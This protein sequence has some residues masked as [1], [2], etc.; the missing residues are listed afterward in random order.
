MI[1]APAALCLTLALPATAA[2]PSPASV[3][4]LF[5]LAVRPPNVHYKGRKLVVTRHGNQSL[6]R[7][8][9][10]Y[11]SPPN[12]WRHEVLGPS[13]TVLKTTI[14]SGRNEWIRAAGSDKVILRDVRRIRR[15]EFDGESLHGLLR[16]NY[17]LK[18]AGKK[19][20]LGIQ[21]NGIILEPR[22]GAGSKRALWVDP[23]TG[24]VVLRRESSHDGKRMQESR[25]TRLEIA[26]NLPSELFRPEFPDDPEV[27]EEDER[28][29]IESAAHLA[30]LGLARSLWRESLPFGYRLDSVNAVAVGPETVVHMRYTNGL[31]LLSLFVSPRAIDAEDLRVEEGLDPASESGV[32]AVTWAGGVLIWKDG[33]RHFLLVGDLSRGKLAHLR[34][35]LRPPK[36]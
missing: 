7:E 18:N 35:L 27:V 13:G 19:E 9:K 12:R 30:G 34:G 14:Q 21:A 15:G 10:V 25:L 23:A 11:Y 6:A 1:S 26:E 36:D 33:G 22:A 4:I 8:V 28:P 2:A 20:F 32:A 16:A 24:I 5:S 31:S 29:R 17:E 3:D